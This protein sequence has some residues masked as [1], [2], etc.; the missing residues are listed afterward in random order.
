MY[1]R[2]N[3]SLALESQTI[4]RKKVSNG[5]AENIFKNQLD[6]IIFMVMHK[7]LWDTS[8]ANMRQ[9]NILS[10]VLES[11]RCVHIVSYV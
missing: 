8:E 4:C 6:L 1:I 2:K 9:K 11:S 5:Q 10:V 3:K 7:C